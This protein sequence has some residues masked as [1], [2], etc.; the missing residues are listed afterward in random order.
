MTSFL[1]RSHN[2]TFCTSFKSK[3]GSLSVYVSGATNATSLKLSVFANACATVMKGVLRG[4]NVSINQIAV[5]K[6]MVNSMLS[7][8][9]DR[10]M[11]AMDS[12]GSVTWAILAIWLQACSVWA[13]LTSWRDSSWKTGSTSFKSLASRTLLAQKVVWSW[14]T[15]SWSMRCGMSPIRLWDLTSLKEFW[16]STRHNSVA[17]VSMI[18]T[19]A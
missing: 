15:Q 4:T 9:K 18:L 3:R 2:Q 19:S 16:E 17:T 6:W 5:H 14:L 12:L 13:I 8:F 1:L 7:R 10:E 11:H